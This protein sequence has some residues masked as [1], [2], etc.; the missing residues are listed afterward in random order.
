MGGWVERS[1]PHLGP[2]QERW[3]SL[4]STHPTELRN[5]RH[6]LNRVTWEPDLLNSIAW[7]IE[8]LERQVS[9]T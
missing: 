3:V 8:L 9:A 7:G 2:S 1:E 5:W 6:A 4:R